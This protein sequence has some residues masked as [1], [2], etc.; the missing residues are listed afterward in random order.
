MAAPKKEKP[1][2]IETIELK[3]ASMTAWLL[4]ETPFFCNRM[5]AKAKRELLMP[6]GTLSKSQRA[7]RL[8]HAPF[9]EFRDSPYI[10]RGEGETKIMMVGSSVKKAIATAALDMPTSVAKAQINRLVSTPEEY[11]PIWGIPRLDMS[12]VRQ[13]GMS[14]TPDVRTRAKIARWATRVRIRWAEPMLN[15]TAIGQLLFAS[16]MICGIGDWRQ[17]KGGGSNGLYRVVEPDD[18]ELREVLETGGYLAQE[19]A[20]RDPVCANSETEEL[21]Q[22]YLEE[23]ARRGLSPETERAED[24]EIDEAPAELI[25]RLPNGEDDKPTVS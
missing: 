25:D 1:I 23:L 4:G 22:W 18:P 20:M 15:R 5:A 16:G 7:T 2:E 17:E 6:R 24:V 13:A 19:E 10:R 8:K 14:R 3:D 12:I 11:I 21:L 9:A